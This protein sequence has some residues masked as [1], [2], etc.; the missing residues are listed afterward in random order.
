MAPA[1]K[2]RKEIQML[3]RL[4][5]WFVSLFE[6]DHSTK[7]NEEVKQP[8]GLNLQFFAEEDDE[9]D[10]DVDEGDDDNSDEDDEEDDSLDLDELLKDPEFKKQYNKRFKKQMAR[11]LK[12]FDGID[13]EEY[14]RLKEQ[15]GKKKDKQGNE[16]DDDETETLREQLQA[17][18]KK[19]LR[20]ERREKRAMVKEYAVDNQVNPKLLSRLINVDD[21][22]LDED[23]EADNLD[24]LFEELEEEFPEYFGVTDD[25]DDEEEYETR[26]KTRRS[27]YVPGAR[28]KGN[29]KKKI[30]PKE[31]G[32]QKALER[33]KKEDE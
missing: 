16:D 28:K 7:T 8:L 1:P 29:K 25:E 15:A 33:H 14:R 26:K 31:A 20:A 9:G 13:P 27:T 24:D 4:Y 32:R 5:L 11:R 10:D 22:E 18:E 2:Q 12:K 19:L 30:D 21:I 23:G 3:K 6:R 17:K